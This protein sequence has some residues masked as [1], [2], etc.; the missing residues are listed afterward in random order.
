MYNND[1]LRKIKP[2][3]FTKNLKD[4]CKRIASNYI[5]STL[6]TMK[7]FPIANQEWFNSIYTY[8]SNYTKSIVI[9]DKNLG[10]LIKNYFNLYFNNKL[11][12]NKRVVTRFRRLITNKIF[13]SKAE[14]KH[15]SSKIIITL[16]VYNEERRI[17]AHRLNRIEAML[18]ASSSYLSS[19]LDKNNFLSFKDKLNIIKREKENVS[20]KTLLDELRFPISEEI[21]LEKENLMRIKTLKNHKE[22]QLE[23]KTLEKNLDD[24]LNIIVNYKY[25]SFSHNIYE[26]IYNKFIGKIL[27]EKEIITIAYYKL[28]LSLNKSKFEDKFILNLKPLI[29][30]IYNKEVEFNII[31]LKAVYLNSDIFTQAISLKLK[32]RNNGLLKVLRSFL[33]MVKLPKINVM[34]ERFGYINPKNLW[35]NLVKNLKVNYLFYNNKDSLNQLLSGL[36]QNSNFIKELEQYKENNKYVKYSNNITSNNLLNCVFNSLKYKSIGGVRLEA[37]GRLTRRFT[38]S[39]SVFKIKWKGS[40]KNIDSSYRGLSSV[41]LRGYIKSNVQYSIINSKTRNGAFGLKGWISGK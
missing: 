21:K 22:K 7:Y 35:I 26:K 32:N 39:R 37:K 29:S 41:I 34:R 31:N 3:I 24:L 38:A 27:L 23:I 33:Y 5:T 6:G 11:I 40:L 28:L 36:L 25:N 20:F 15:T 8:D 13:V 1:K 4:N 16:Y 17:L 30:K 14:L 19:E 18:F 9:A 10:R 2:L 12:A